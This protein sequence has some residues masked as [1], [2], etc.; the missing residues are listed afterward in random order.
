M[1]SP[2]LD[3]LKNA[4]PLGDVVGRR[5]DAV[6]AALE[7]DCHHRARQAPREARIDDLL[8][9]YRLLTGKRRARLSALEARLRGERR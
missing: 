6:S 5:H 7:R 8:K 4:V 2:A 1:N 3:D 9:N